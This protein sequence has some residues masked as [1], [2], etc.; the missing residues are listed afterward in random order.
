MGLL[1]SGP[2]AVDAV[3]H[4]APRSMTPWGYDLFPVVRVHHALEVGHIETM[5][6]RVEVTWDPNAAT[7][8]AS[9]RARVVVLPG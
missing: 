6:L 5:R 4:L 9:L 7:V 8:D 1:P 2:H 3:L